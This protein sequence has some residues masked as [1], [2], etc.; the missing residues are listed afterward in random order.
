MFLI[1]QEVVIV[2]AFE[3]L[4]VSFGHSILFERVEVHGF[5]KVVPLVDFVV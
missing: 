2:D 3:Q 5:C 4:L 1:S